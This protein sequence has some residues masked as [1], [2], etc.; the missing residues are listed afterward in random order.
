MQGS[1][2]LG[3][4]V[5]RG[6]GAGESWVSLYMSTIVLCGLGVALGGRRSRIEEPGSSEVD[7]MWEKGME[8][9]STQALRA[10]PPPS[11]CQARE[12]PE[13]SEYYSEYC[14]IVCCGLPSPTA[15]HF[16]ERSSCLVSGFLWQSLK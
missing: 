4:E 6:M 1:P 15:V 3:L 10:I 5:T 12:E 13:C 8:E 14:E 9:A 16:P 7:L 2:Y 11:P